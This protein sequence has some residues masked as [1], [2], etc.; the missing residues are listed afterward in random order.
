M[1]DPMRSLSKAL[2][3]SIKRRCPFAKETRLESGAAGKILI[4]GAVEVIDRDT[5]K[6]KPRRKHAKYLDTRSGRIRL[7]AIRDRHSAP[8]A[9][10]LE[11]VLEGE[12]EMLAPVIALELEQTV[13]VGNFQ[14]FLLEGGEKLLVDGA[15]LLLVRSCWHGFLRQLRRNGPPGCARVVAVH[16]HHG[17]QPI[18]LAISTPK[19]VG[20]PG[21]RIRGTMYPRRAAAG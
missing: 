5:N 21:A 20:A 6:A 10:L 1:I 9:L 17:C 18:S 15:S 2:S 4:I 8:P 12:L 14:Q 7:A 13:P 11:H 19:I 16:N 3:R